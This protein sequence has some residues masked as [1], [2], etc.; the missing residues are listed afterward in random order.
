M[1]RTG[2]LMYHIEPWRKGTVLVGDIKAAKVVQAAI[3]RMIRRAHLI[4]LLRG[5]L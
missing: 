1:P 2:R 3:L 4:E 5:D